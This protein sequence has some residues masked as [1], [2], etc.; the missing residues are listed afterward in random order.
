MLE[1]VQ[2]CDVFSLRLK[3]LNLLCTV[4]VVAG[5]L[6]FGDSKLL[7]QCFCCACAVAC[8]E[9]RFYSRV[10]KLFYH[11]FYFGLRFVCECDESLGKLVAAYKYYRFA[12]AFKLI[13]PC[14]KLRT[15]TDSL[16]LNPVPAPDSERG[17]AGKRFNSA[18]LFLQ[19][20]AAY[21]REVSGRGRL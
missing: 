19:M 12:F 18:P 21:A 15:D 5:S 3:K 7:R 17:S 2:K 4:I 13:C 20:S 8:H 16:L 6:V 9:N 1:C 10:L 14:L 11:L